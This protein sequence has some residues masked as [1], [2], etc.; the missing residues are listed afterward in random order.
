MLH[1]FTRRKRLESFCTS[2][3]RGAVVQ[4]TGE[5]ARLSEVIFTKFLERLNRLKLSNGDTSDLI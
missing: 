5:E 4:R 3:G 2:T 1:L